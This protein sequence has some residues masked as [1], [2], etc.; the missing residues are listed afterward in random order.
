VLG[1]T[2]IASALHFKNC[3]QASQDKLNNVVAF[4]RSALNHLVDS[5]NNN[6]ANNKPFK[7][8]HGKTK[9]FASTLARLFALVFNF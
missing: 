3:L 2:A 5:S 7:G 8:F 4:E 6:A 9:L 1:T